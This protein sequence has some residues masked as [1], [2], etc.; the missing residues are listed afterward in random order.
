MRSVTQASIFCGKERIADDV[1]GGLLSTNYPNLRN[2]WVVNGPKQLAEYTTVRPLPDTIYLGQP[3]FP[4]KQSF[5]PLL[6]ERIKRKQAILLAWKAIL[7]MLIDGDTDVWFVE[8][9]VKVLPDTLT[10]LQELVGETGAG[11]ISATTLSFGKVPAFRLS[12]NV[13][14][15]IESPLPTSTEIDFVGMYCCYF[16]QSTIRLLREYTPQLEVPGHY[17]LGKDMHLCYWLKAMGLKIVLAPHFVKM[18]Q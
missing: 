17:M 14:T 2:L 7:P 16:P 3:V 8:D 15:Q 12:C 5:A 18:L 10:K 4:K 9:D 13:A 1:V 6:A 11:L